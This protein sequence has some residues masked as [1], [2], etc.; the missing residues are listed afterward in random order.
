MPNCVIITPSQHLHHNAS[1]SQAVR[2]RACLPDL[3][4]RLLL[5]LQAEVDA[6]LGADAAPGGLAQYQQL[7]YVSRCVAESMRLYPHP[8]VLL[9]RALGPD[10]LP[11]GYEVA[12]GQDVMISVY[13]IHHSP[14]VRGEWGRG[15]LPGPASFLEGR[16]GRGSGIGWV[17]GWVNVYMFICVCNASCVCMCVCACV[18]HT[19]CTPPLL[20][21]GVGRPR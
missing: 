14:E 15:W 1:P 2:V 8:P 6:V 21:P 4:C 12:P 18:C 5:L 10:V 19:S 3:L 20:L 16:W 17:G 7:A 11:G 9:R 13:N